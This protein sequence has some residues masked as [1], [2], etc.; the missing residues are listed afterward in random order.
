MKLTRTHHLL[1]KAFTCVGLLPLTYASESVYPFVR[2]TVQ[3]GADAWKFTPELP[4]ALLLL[5]TNTE[6]P[7]RAISPWAKFDGS[8]WLA[9]N[10]R[11]N[12]RARDDQN[13]GSRIDDM[14]LTWDVSPSL[15]INAG[16]VSYKT[17]WCRTYETDSPWIRENNPFCTVTTTNLAVGGAPGVQLYANTVHG[18][19]RVQWLVGL[20][21]PLMFDYDTQEYSNTLYPDSTVYQN[22]KSGLSMNVLNLNTATEFRLG[23]LDTR[24]AAYVHPLWDRI[25]FRSRQN[26]QVYFAGLSYQLSPAVSMRAQVMRHEMASSQWSLQGSEYP[27]YFGGTELLRQSKAIEIGYQ[28]TEQDQLAMAISEYTYIAG[29]RATLY[30]NPGYF[31]VPSSFT[32]KNKGVSV[33]W[34]HDW[35]RGV[36]TIVQ[37]SRNE[38]QLR[39]LAKTPI[40][41]RSNAATAIGV[42]LGYQF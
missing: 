7:Y 38:L 39:N 41:D 19:Y 29:W 24:Q 17:T 13:M 27:N 14:S 4:E 18:D 6:K 37:L 23:V 9:N 2:S 16:V 22:E 33:S 21:R 36:H 12:L 30:P 28:H 40:E 25:G 10:W 42:R 20:Y 8:V 26:Y 15:G 35:E 11:L 32:Y 3:V 1:I 34:R 5:A 31:Y